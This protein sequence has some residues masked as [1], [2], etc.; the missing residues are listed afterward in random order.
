MAHKYTMV[1]GK[2]KRGIWWETSRGYLKVIPPAS[3][4]LTLT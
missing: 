4:L 3:E 1:R 2:G